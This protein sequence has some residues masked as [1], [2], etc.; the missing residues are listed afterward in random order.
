MKKVYGRASSNNLQTKRHTVYNNTSY[1]F[2]HIITAATLPNIICGPC[3]TMF[4]DTEL[5]AIQSSKRVI[6]Q[7]INS[8]CSLNNINRNKSVTLNQRVS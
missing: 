3:T 7:Q 6:C 8:A 2:T 5:F 4:V 1:I